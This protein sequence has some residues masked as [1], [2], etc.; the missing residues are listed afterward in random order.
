[1][2]LSKRLIF[3]TRGIAKHVWFP[4]K[5]TRKLETKTGR[6]QSVQNFARKSIPIFEFYVLP[7]FGP[8]VA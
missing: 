4:M 1:M 2:S 8:G 6:V 5:P 3:L 7:S